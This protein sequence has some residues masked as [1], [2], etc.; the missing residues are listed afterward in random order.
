MKKAFIILFLLVFIVTGNVYGGQVVKNSESNISLF[1]E[2]SEK[3]EISLG[4]IANTRGVDIKAV[5]FKSDNKSLPDN[6]LLWQSGVLNV[7]MSA[8]KDAC[9]NIITNLSKITVPEIW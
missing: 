4:T 5:Y 9:N 6:K 7:K 2:L 3:R 8:D 1:N